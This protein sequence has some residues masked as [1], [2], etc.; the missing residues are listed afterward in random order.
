MIRK[1]WKVK[2]LDPKVSRLSKKH[3]IPEILVQVFLNRSIEEDDFLKFLNP[4]IAELH[5]SLLLPDIEKACSRIKKAVQ[6]SED[7]LVFGDYDVDGITSLAIFNEYAKQYPGVFSFYIPHRVKEGYGLNKKAIQKAKN[8]GS[9]LIIAFDCGTSSHEEIKLA[10]SFGIDVIVVDHHY[11][12]KE[13]LGA[14]AFVNPKR[15]DSEYPFKELS[16]GALSFKLLQVLTASSCSQVLDLVALST[17][18]DVVPLQGEN[19]NLLIQ[20]LRILRESPRPSIKALCKTASTKQQNLDTFHIG[21]ILGPRIN[22][23]GRI[24]HPQDALELFLTEDEKKAAKFAS[25][26]SEYNKLR[27]ATEVQIL[28]EAEARI[29]NNAD[30]NCAIVVSGESWHPGVLGIV[31]SRLADKYYRPAFVFSFDNGLGKGSA[32]SIQSVHLMQMLDKCADSLITYGGHKKAAGVNI[33]EDELENFREKINTLIDEELDKED[34]IPTLDIDARIDFS[35]INMDL[36][37]GLEKM[38]PYGEGN[39]KP[40]FASYNISKRGEPQKISSFHS[41]WLDDGERTFEGIVYDK[42][43][44]ELLD[45]TEEFDIAFS[46]EKNHYHNAPKLV[47]RD[48][49]FSCGTESKS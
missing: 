42:D 31:A 46:L 7:V 16:T 2:E 20:G 33:N 27:R 28:K 19:R 22:A 6:E 44:I 13:E 17:V 34:F 8:E 5:N 9:K 18:C 3:N 29:N 14:Y 45:F 25:K 4:S 24:A 43:I 41:V 23:S 39:S 11:V 1:T 37:E 40:L 48:A 10:R 26:L 35:S 49:R 30:D 36:V 15:P 21:Y 32:R 38:K 12:G 47:I